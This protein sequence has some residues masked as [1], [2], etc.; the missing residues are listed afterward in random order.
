MGAVRIGYPV[1]CTRRYIRTSP[2]M[3][4]STTSLTS[5]TSRCPN[6]FKSARSFRPAQRLS[7]MSVVAQSR[8]EV[9]ERVV[10][11]MRAVELVHRHALFVHTGWPE[12]GC[13]VWT[14]S[15]GCCT[16]FFRR[17]AMPTQASC[18]CKL[19]TDGLACL[20]VLQSLLLATL[21]LILRTR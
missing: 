19:S 3:A 8:Q 5:V 20:Q 13:D 4:T 17:Y 15:I 1:T 6:S 12:E 7:R 21:P 2:K 9:G 18:F 11:S 14:S 10:R 16:S